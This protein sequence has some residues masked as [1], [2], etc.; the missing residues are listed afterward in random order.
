MRTK[1]LLASAA[2]LAMGLASSNA[3]VYSAN[4]VGYIN[5]QMTNP[6]PAGLTSGYSL[7]A[8]QLDLDG[9][10]LNNSIYTV[11][12]TNVPAG[13]VVEA[14]AGSGFV[15]SKLLASGKW[16]PNSQNITN[17]MNPGQGFFIVYPSNSSFTE[18]GNV[19]QGTNSYPI[20]PGNQAVAFKSPISGTIDTTFGYV[21]SKGDLVEVWAGGGFVTHKWLGASW[22]GGDPT[23]NVAQGV[24]LNAASNNVWQQGFT[25]H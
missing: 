21:P 8:N 5:V 1:I 13:T 15:T 7:V 18:V 20:V 17:A 6:P 2:A 24:F 10:G 16:T 22:S 25:V 19:V 11:V 9:T 14:W 23:I 12:G 4:V 3:Q